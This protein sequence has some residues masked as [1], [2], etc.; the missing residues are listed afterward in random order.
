MRWNLKTTGS[1]A[2]LKD[3][4]VPKYLFATDL[5]AFK[6]MK[7]GCVTWRTYKQAS[8][9]DFVS[10]SKIST[11]Q[12][13]SGYHA[14]M[15]MKPKDYKLVFGDEKLLKVMN[16][17][18]RSKVLTLD[19]EYFIYSLANI[20]NSEFIV[21]STSNFISVLNLQTDESVSSEKRTLFRKSLKFSGSRMVY[22]NAV[23]KIFIYG[24][25]NAM[26]LRFLDL[27][28]K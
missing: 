14:Y 17:K 15:N 27:K 21:V 3:S 6:G 7:F 4:K 5:T 2:N 18:E 13:I 24:Y 9:F 16:Y 12:D 19:L 26:G 25:S 28:K 11:I 22:N 10:M 23:N 1:F 20:D 8:I